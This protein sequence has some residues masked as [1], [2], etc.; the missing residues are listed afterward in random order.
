MRKA[1][2]ERSARDIFVNIYPVSHQMKG[3]TL[4]FTFFRYAE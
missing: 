1:L 2:S 4:Y 3:M